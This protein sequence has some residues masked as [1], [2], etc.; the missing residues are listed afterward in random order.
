MA[1]Q[2]YLAEAELTETALREHLATHTTEQF[3][4]TIQMLRREVAQLRGV[5]PVRPDEEPT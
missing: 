4:M 5:S 2:A 1:T 3:A